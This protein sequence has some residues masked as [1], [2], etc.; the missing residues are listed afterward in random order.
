MP[1]LN[2]EAVRFTSETAAF[3]ADATA[4]LLV[5]A[6]LWDQKP[7]VTP[8][9]RVIKAFE[10]NDVH[11]D[12]DGSAWYCDGPDVRLLVVMRDGRAHLLMMPL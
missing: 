11:Y 2:S 10:G 3:I 6:R 1:V 8:S 7:D 4:R 12:P 5:V 9:E